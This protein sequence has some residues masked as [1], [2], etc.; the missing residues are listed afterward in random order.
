MLISQAAGPVIAAL[1]SVPPSATGPYTGAQSTAA[2]RASLQ[3]ALDNYKTGRIN[4]AP[5]SIADTDDTRSFGESHA[6]ELDSIGSGHGTVSGIGPLTPPQGSSD[7]P[8]THT[9]PPSSFHQSNSG[10]PNRNTLSP[11]IDPIQLNHSPAPIPIPSSGNTSTTA[12]VPIG[13]PEKSSPML[14]PILPTVAETGVP[15]SA[16]AGGPGPASGS[17]LSIKSAAADA[18]P[19]SGGLS[20][21]QPSDSGYGQSGA[22]G[23]AI[24]AASSVAS[25][26]SGSPSK[27]YESAEDEK[28]RLQKEERERILSAQGPP[29]SSAS[30]Q[31]ES[32]E[33]EKK[34]LERQ[35]RERILNAAGPS[36]AGQDPPKDGGDDSELPAYQAF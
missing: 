27:Q 22:I 20:G 5:D 17:L 10:I 2:T 23:A 32:A 28:K 34:R 12:A 3:R 29:P 8:T 33:E 11:P 24:A 9:S 16:G 26:T 6:S 14:P 21:S 18:G 4:L 35:E 19:K 30:G 13:S 36:G 1:P 7:L 25:V 15:V 31:F